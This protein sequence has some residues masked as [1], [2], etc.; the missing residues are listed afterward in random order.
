MVYAKFP[1]I[2][3]MDENGNENGIKREPDLSPT[4]VAASIL[5]R[6]PCVHK[7]DGLI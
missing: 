1:L 7:R 5:V 2:F 3:M 6:A 4:R